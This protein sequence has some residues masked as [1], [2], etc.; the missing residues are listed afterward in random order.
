[1]LLAYCNHGDCCATTFKNS[2]DLDSRADEDVRNLAE[3]FVVA[4]AAERVQRRLTACPPHVRKNWLLGVARR[5]R[6][7][8]R[9]LSTKSVIQALPAIKF[10]FEEDDQLDWCIRCS[11][12]EAYL[13]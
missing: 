9:K 2:A 12:M 3:L 8:A 6:E 4:S 10:V 11:L 13:A 1:M 7:E 5:E